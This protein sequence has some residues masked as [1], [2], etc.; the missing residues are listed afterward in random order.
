MSPCK[1]RDECFQ[2]LQ[3]LQ[4]IKKGT[5][6]LMASNAVEQR[7]ESEAIALAPPTQDTAGMEAAGGKE[8]PP[9]VSLEAPKSAVLSPVETTQFVHASATSDRVAAPA[10]PVAIARR[11][12]ERDVMLDEFELIVDEVAT[13]RCVRPT[14]CVD[15]LA[16]R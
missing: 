5:V 7:S 6:A 9:H 15:W 2:C 3:Q 16:R 10:L 8:S 11:I 1:Y 13:F 12:P 14:A 4:A